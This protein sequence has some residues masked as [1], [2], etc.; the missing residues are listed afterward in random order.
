MAIIADIVKGLAEPVTDLVSEFIEDKDK[1]AEIA[2]KIET[3]AATQA[4][5]IAMAQIAVN[6]EEAKGG[7]FRAG[8]RPSVGWVCVVT[9]ANNY[10]ITPYAIAMGFEVPSLD[11]N[12]LM[13]ILLGMLGLGYLRTDEK[14]AGLR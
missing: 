11:L 13:P 6:Q 7:W 5:A 2:Y 1:A 9:L 8:W 12:S 10:V 14:K 4:H 3:M